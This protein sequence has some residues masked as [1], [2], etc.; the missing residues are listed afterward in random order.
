MGLVHHPPCPRL[1]Q[2]SRRDKGAFLLVFLAVVSCLLFAVHGR[3]QR[4]VALCNAFLDTAH[5]SS[6]QKTRHA[7]VE[8]TVGQARH[9]LPY[10]GEEEA[11][12]S[13]CTHVKTRTLPTDQRSTDRSVHPTPTTDPL[14]RSSR[15]TEH[16]RASA[17]R[18]AATTLV[19]SHG[20]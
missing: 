19:R 17:D 16:A 11:L 14:D 13:H 9:W 3:A 20:V 4:S 12:P 18:D 7:V 15:P 10:S 5:A 8:T 6:T 1:L 2:D